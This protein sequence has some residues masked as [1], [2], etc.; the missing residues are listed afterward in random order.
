MAE[1]VFTS[2]GIKFRERDLTFVT[3]NVGVTTL[4][5]VGETLKGP[6]FEPVLV[7]DKTQL[8]TRFGFQSNEKLSSGALKYHLPYVASAYLEESSQLY[9]TRVLGLSG[10]DAGT[11]WALTLSAGVDTST[12]GETASVAGTF[13]FSGG[14]YLGVTI[15]A[16][17]DTGSVFSG[18]TK[19]GATGFSGDRI[20]ITANTYNAGAGTGVTLTSTIG[21]TS[22]TA[23]EDMV[24]AVIRSRATV[25]DVTD[26]APTTTFDATAVTITANNTNTGVGDLF[27]LFDI[28]AVGA[29]GTE[30]YTASLDPSSKEYLPS[31]LGSKPKGKNNKLWV[32]KI[33]PN[34][35]KKLDADSLAYGVNTGII[36][37]DVASYTDYTDQYLTPETPW[38]VSELRGSEI[39][40]L[41]KLISIADGNAANQEIKI[42]ITNIDPVAKEF[43]VIIRDFN[44]TD[45]NQVILESFSRCTMRESE[46]NFIGNRIGTSDGN[47][48]LRSEY[49]MLELDTNIT[50][51]TFPAGFE[52]YNQN[53]WATSATTSANAGIAPE[54]FYKTGYTTE[55]KLNK[56]FL[57]ISE[58]GYDGVSLQGTGIDLNQFTYKGKGA[59][60]KSKGF[61]MDSGATGT[62][63]DGVQSIGQFQVGAGNF[64]VAGDISVATDTYYELASRKFTLVPAGGYDGWNEHRL[65]RSNTD[66]YRAGGWAECICNT[67]Y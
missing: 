11:A 25:A 8:N 49:V 17:G 1:F 2:P 43:N 60:V 45:A 34:L 48:P 62:Y 59:F 12:S 7:Q 13:S 42:S 3:R 5:L 63:T 47:Y 66:R 65:S 23:Y 67:G 35:I 31:V 54:L 58:N 15:S 29:D 6:A 64:R 19:T 21:A 51:D 28:T 27:G 32:E 44:D 46:V 4:G 10:Y 61:H 41:F 30:V 36:D 50:Q 14:S 38:V 57:G 52:G 16:T 9:I 55:E 53:N 22:Y 33:Y 39:E 24:V 18:Y 40:R 56:T 20:F 26:A 37:A